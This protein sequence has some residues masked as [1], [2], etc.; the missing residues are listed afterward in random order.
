MEIIQNSQKQ[1][2]KPALS[3]Q[4]YLSLTN[5]EEEVVEK[6]IIVDDADFEL[7]NCLEGEEWMFQTFNTKKKLEAQ[8]ELREAEEKEKLAQ[9][10]PPQP[11]PSTNE[12]LDDL[13]D[14]PDIEDNCDQE[15]HHGKL[16]RRRK[17]SKHRRTESKTFN[18]DFL[19]SLAENCSN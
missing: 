18:K 12:R 3:N 14:N 15:S 13:K 16:R 5:K 10:M 7:E 11:T 19:E 8:R 1:T 6:N 9:A 4:K 2:E 17:N